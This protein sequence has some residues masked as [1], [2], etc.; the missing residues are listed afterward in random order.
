MAGTDF[1]P[2]EEIEKKYSGKS[3]LQETLSSLRM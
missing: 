3:F 2:I 1:D